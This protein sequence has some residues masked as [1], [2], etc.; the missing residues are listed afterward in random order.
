MAH[1]KVYGICENKC[2]IEV[3]S[4]N[5]AATK[6]SVDDTISEL[7]KLKINRK[8]INANTEHTDRVVLYNNTKNEN[9]NITQNNYVPPGNPLV[10]IFRMTTSTGSTLKVM[11][12]TS[13]GSQTIVTIPANQWVLIEEL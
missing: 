2:M 11:Q 13:P 4:K 3:L 5:K 7:N 10:I 1:D 8:H 6:Q 12:W 9:V